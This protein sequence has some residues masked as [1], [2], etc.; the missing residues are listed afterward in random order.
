MTEKKPPNVLFL[1]WDAARVDYVQDH[2]P[3]LN[4][5]RQENLWFENT[6]APSTW[7]LPSHPSLFNGQVPS[8]HGCY[9]VTDQRIDDLPLVK[10][11]SEHNYETYSVSGN[12][13]AN[14]RNGF[15]TPFDDFVYTAD[16][17]PFKKG[18]NVTDY[19]YRLRGE[20]DD[21]TTTDIAKMSF[22]EALSHDYPARSLLNF[23]TVL[24]NRLATRASILQKLPH[25]LFDAN[26]QYSYSPSRNTAEIKSFIDDATEPFFLF[27]NYMDTHRPY[28]PCSKHR[29]NLAEPIPY[30]E[31]AK[32]N[33][34]AAPWE[35]IKRTERGEDLNAEL[36]R[37]R[38][39]YAGEVT[40]VDDHLRQLV[41]F[42]KT[43]DCYENT[44]II[45][46]SDHG[47]NLGET[48]LLG[49]Q[50]MG[51]EASI[52]EELMQVPLLVA[53]PSFDSRS[54]SP[55][56]SNRRIFD[57]LTRI[58]QSDSVEAEAAIESIVDQSPVCVEYP[59]TD[60]DEIFDKHPDVPREALG[61][62]TSVHQSVAIDGEWIT[63]ADSTGQRL[64]FEAGTERAYQTAPETLKTAC[65][66]RLERLCE[67]DTKDTNL[68]E[69]E[70]LQLEALGYL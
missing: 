65:E 53:N 30:S 48:D 33:R 16:W 68:S 34:I 12:G 66:D 56:V 26:T 61:L 4:E 70:M 49:N 24:V 31:A 50:R 14:Q 27:A 20:T 10:A 67:N 45:V 15:D 8:E 51:H 42:L 6:Y 40:A 58:L 29:D 18:L 52:S 37:I 39:L 54:I 5:L 62:R 9:R 57:Y 13:F 64:A 23:G 38:S 41:S 7:S 2:A 3:F 59:A 35:F 44:I 1:V 63:I 32:L 43:N 28:Y 60:G 17:G 22:V 25:P 46:T 55:A 69:E 36:E 21:I 19:S 11:F 47:E